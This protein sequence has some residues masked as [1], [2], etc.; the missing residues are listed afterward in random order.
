MF[1][2]KNDNYIHDNNIDTNIMMILIIIGLV[3]IIII[4]IMMKRIIPK[5]RIPR[6]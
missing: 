6:E 2:N 5:F 3:V 1:D 4:I